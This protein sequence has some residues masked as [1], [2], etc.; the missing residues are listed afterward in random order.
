MSV[1]AT[2]RSR[3]SLTAVASLM[4]VT[5]AACG[6]SAQ[7]TAEPTAS[8]STSAPTT[9]STPPPASTSTQTPSASPSQA[10]LGRAAVEPTPVSGAGMAEH[11]HNLAYDGERLLIGTHQG[12]WLQ[13]SGQKPEQVSR[14]SFDVMGFTRTGDRWLASGHPGPGM[15]APAGLGLLQ[16]TDQGR[17]WD[18]VS[19]GGEV[20]FHRL[21]TSGDVVV[22]VNA[23]DG[24]MLR[25]DDGGRSWVDLGTVGLYD[26]VIS[27]VDPSVLVGTTPDGPVRSTDGGATFTPVPEA[28]L[29]ALL[30]WTGAAL[31]GIDVEGTVYA[32]TDD[33]VT[34]ERRGAVSEQP[35]ALAADG[36]RIAAL[37]GNRIVESTDGGATFSPRIRDI[38][39]H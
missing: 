30:A 2:R 28:S 31:Y 29:L 32:S 18:E 22:G 11:V 8:S 16:S 19:L 14:D 21:V 7:T 3:M 27:P 24:R 33:G 23:H 13:A 15:D 6:S 12:L 34:W 39:G 20:D 35:A 5:L 26:V 10:E 37:V 9:S 1:L 25:S 4:T 38:P 17:T 36:N